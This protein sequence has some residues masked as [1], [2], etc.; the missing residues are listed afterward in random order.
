MF[1]R[2]DRKENDTGNL[3]PDACSKVL[4]AGRFLVFFF[5]LIHHVPDFYS[6]TVDNW[7]FRYK[8]KIP[9]G[10][11]QERRVHE[12]WTG[13]WHFQSSKVEQKLAWLW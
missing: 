11:V 9:G 12:D 2:V 5:F 10:R 3:N 8:I 13:T 1:P 6:V 4:Y 7:A